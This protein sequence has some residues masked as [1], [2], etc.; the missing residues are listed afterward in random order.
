LGCAATQPYR[1]LSVFICVHP[2]LKFSPGVSEPN[3]I[4]QR[5]LFHIL[6]VRY[7]SVMTKQFQPL[8]M[9]AP[10]SGGFDFIK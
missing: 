4:A 2:W 7:N 8:N 3:R 1:K 10:V 6:P 9:R 5:S